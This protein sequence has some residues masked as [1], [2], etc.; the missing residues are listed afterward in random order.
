MPSIRSYFFLFLSFTSG[1][2]V[3]QVDTFSVIEEIEIVAKPIRSADISG[4]STTWNT[5]DLKSGVANTV[6]DLLIR[7][8]N[9]Y[10]KNYGPGSLA[11]SSFRGGSASQT[12][13]LWNDLPIQSPLLGQL[14]ISLLPTWSMDKVSLDKGGNSAMWGSGAIGGTVHLEHENKEKGSYVV[15]NLLSFGSFGQFQENLKLSFATRKLRSNTSFTYLKAEN[16]FPYSV[17]TANEVRKVQSNAAQEQYHIN[18]DLYYKL[19][20]RHSIELHY[21]RTSAD[22]QIPPTTV[23]R[24]NDA[25]QIDNADRISARWKFVYGSHRIKL[26][27]GLFDEGLEFYDPTQRITSLTNFQTY[28]LDYSHQYNYREKHRFSYGLSA[29]NTQVFS[30]ENYDEDPSELRVAGLFRYQYD[31][32]RLTLQLSGRQQ[33]VDDLIVPF[34]P[35]AAFSYDIGEFKWSGKVSNN[36][37]LPTLNDR[38]WSPGG[39][40]N[41]KPES[42]WSAESSLNWLRKR[43]QSQLSSSITAYH[44]V[45][46]NWIQW[47]I[48]EGSS[49]WQPY[50]L[51]RVW[52]RGIEYA[53]NYDLEMGKS[54]LSLSGN[55][56]YVKSTNQIAIDLPRLE[57]GQ[58]LW[59]TPEYTITGSL[60]YSWKGFK[61]EYIQRWI[62]GTTGINENLDPF[63]IGDVL[64]NKSVNLLNFKGN[65]FLNIFNVW[66]SQYRVV[67][68]RPMPGANF[69]LGLRTSIESNK[70]V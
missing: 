12:L 21:W 30:A 8:G 66:N 7:K 31:G 46:D 64:L 35:A 15:D 49:F 16:D 61:A 41:L 19:N 60:A 48:L 2:T 58:Q 22:R 63:T 9:V 17:G 36:F 26:N 47:S 50:N 33:I 3:A 18:Q 14:D 68:R 39:N 54:M 24:M 13:I 4:S 29:S 38:F 59:Y 6:A 23:Q 42:G 57:K 37:R 65:V 28:I 55:A 40:P 34:I 43:D 51:T 25:Y 62:D 5:E 10:I 70:K 56:E 45:I 20:K 52:S 11:T 53:V 67:E 69:Q 1:W 32:D 44:K 27:A